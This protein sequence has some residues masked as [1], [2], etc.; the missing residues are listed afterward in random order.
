[1][2]PEITLSLSYFKAQ[3]WITDDMNSRL[4]LEIQIKRKQLE[5]SDPVPHN[6]VGTKLLTSLN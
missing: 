2:V 3:I 6:T 5:L 1:M 4:I